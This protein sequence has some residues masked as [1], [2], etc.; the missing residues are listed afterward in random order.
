[1]LT[2]MEVEFGAKVSSEYKLFG[3]ADGAIK[4]CYRWFLESIWL[5]AKTY[6]LF[7]RVKH[8]IKLVELEPVSWARILKDRIWAEAQRVYSQVQC[9]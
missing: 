2:E 1:M 5:Q 3:C 4:E 6:T 7:V 8:V 9:G